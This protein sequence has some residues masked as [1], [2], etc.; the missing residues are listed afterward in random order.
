MNRSVAAGF[1]LGGVLAAAGAL[2]GG[3]TAGT[4]P[5]TVPPSVVTPATFPGAATATPVRENEVPW[6]DGDGVRYENTIV[7]PGGLDVGNGAVRLDFTLDSL[8]QIPGFWGPDAM[9]SFHPETW[10]MTLT[11]GSVVEASTEPEYVT[12]FGDTATERPEGTVRF[13]I[14]DDVAAAD[15]AAIDVVAWRVAVP[16]EA[17]LT[18]DVVNGA[19]GDILDGWVITVR[20]VLE[21]RTNTLIRFD[22]ETPAEGWH[23]PVGGVFGRDSTVRPVG[24]GWRSVS[25]DGDGFQL[26]WSSPD[27]PPTATLCVA[28]VLWRP[29]VGGESLAVYRGP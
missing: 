20:T 27:T 25:I 23:Q 3:A 21:Q 6:V 15:V 24:N 13:E 14:T 2:I 1:V 18:L 22:L 19:S 7:V 17:E 8:G 5:T 9:P 16:V 4:E 10:R 28:T 26:T 11:D 12:D 29:V